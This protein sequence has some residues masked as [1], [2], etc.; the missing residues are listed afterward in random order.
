MSLSLPSPAAAGRWS[1]CA[2]IVLSTL[3]CGSRDPRS[4]DRLTP[5]LE[6]VVRGNNEFAFA[7]YKE[8]AKTPGNVF[9]SPMSIS[10]AFAMTYAG[11]RGD[12]AEEMRS[13]L[14]IQ[15]EDAGYHAQFGALLEDLGGDHTRG[16]RLS[17]ANRLFG[18]DRFP[19]SA[20]FLSLTGTDYGAPLESVDFTTG[21]GEV[22]INDWVSRQTDGAIPELFAPKALGTQTVLVLANAIHFDAD[23]KDPFNT[24][25]TEPQPFFAA[26]G[27]SVEIPLMQGGSVDRY[28]LSEEVSIVTRAYADD[29]LEM[30]LVIPE[31]QHTLA[32]VEA[33]LDGQWFDARMSETRDGS[34]ELAMPRFELRA[35]LPLRGHLEDMGMQRPFDFRADFSGMLASETKELFVSKVAHQAHIRVDERGTEASAATGVAMEP[36][37]THPLFRADRPFFFLIRDRLTSSILFMGRL[38]DPS[39]SPTAE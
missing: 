35:S 13:V 23:W 39:P 37:S 3:A 11:A 6:P 31:G 33:K 8:A 36:K 15:G 18:S 9:F 30:V 10:A 7:L 1:V 29:E 4:I 28:L 12:T 14:R 27:E 38:E 17:I 5:E 22:P 24:L 16:Y 32:D 34:A 20:A 2:A 21:E 25:R 19:F 26:N